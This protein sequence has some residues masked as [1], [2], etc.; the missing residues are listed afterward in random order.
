LSDVNHD[1]ENNAMSISRR[2]VE[3]LLDPVEV[4]LS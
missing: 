4:K 2:S 1:C 3:T